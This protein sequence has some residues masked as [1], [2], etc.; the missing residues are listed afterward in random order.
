MLGPMTFEGI[1]TFLKVPYHRYDRYDRPYSDKRHMFVMGIGY[2]AGTTMRSGARMGPA[3]IREASIFLTDGEH[4]TYSAQINGN[5]LT[6]VGD[7]SVD[8]CNG[9]AAYRT[10][11]D[12][13]E[14]IPE[15]HRFVTLGGDH[16]ITSPI[17]NGLVGN[18][19]KKIKDLAII[20]FDAHCDTWK[21]ENVRYGHETWLRELLE[22]GI[23]PKNVIQIGI[24]SPASK[25]VRSYL[26]ELGGTVISA[27]EAMSYG[28]AEV[29]SRIRSVVGNS[30]V[31]LT[32]DID[33]L[34]PAFAPGTGTP[35]TAGLTTMF[36]Q[37]CLEALP[38][39]QYVGMDV[40]EV[41]PQ[42]DHGQIT[43][44]AAATFAWTWLSM[45]LKTMTEKNL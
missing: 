3:A 35:E 19:A 23:N 29:A 4:P 33:S 1:R 10:I 39:L 18:K 14:N 44:L 11:R 13:F 36:M 31:Y 21:T 41:A 15:Q 26:P 22:N 37:E 12:F 27:R 45:N 7:L 38:Y 24:R 6:D 5:N 42:Y 2:D 30:P 17:I 28:P 43:A 8:N 32:I 20:H 34:D 25:E 9:S 16:S 40:V